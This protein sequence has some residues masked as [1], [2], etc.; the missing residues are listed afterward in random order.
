MPEPTGPVL[1][2]AAVTD[3][4]VNNLSPVPTCLVL[5]HLVTQVSTH[6]EPEPTIRVLATVTLSPIFL[7]SPSPTAGHVTT[8]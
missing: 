7:L 3:L 4:T 2:M 8:F 1:G 6:R 5:G